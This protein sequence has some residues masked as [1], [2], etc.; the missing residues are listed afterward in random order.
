[1]AESV[2]AG[3]QLQNGREEIRRERMQEV[4]TEEKKRRSRWLKNYELRAEL[5][6]LSVRQK[7]R[8]RSL[9]KCIIS[10]QED[11]LLMFI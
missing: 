1:M 7:S 2:D 8:D 4:K 9:N 3:E 11:S 10:A 6:A 5:G